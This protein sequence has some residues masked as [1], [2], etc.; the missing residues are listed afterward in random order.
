MANGR[1]ADVGGGPDERGETAGGHS[2]DS[3]I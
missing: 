2:S 1:D 3:F